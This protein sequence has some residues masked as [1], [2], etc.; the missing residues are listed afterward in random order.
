MTL[1]NFWSKHALMT[2]NPPLHLFV[3]GNS[4]GNCYES[5]YA[6]AIKEPLNQVCSVSFLMSRHTDPNPHL[7]LSTTHN[8]ILIICLCCDYLF[9]INQT[10]ISDGY[11]RYLKDV[12]NRSPGLPIDEHGRLVDKSGATSKLRSRL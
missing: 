6:A 2:L 10:T 8:L 12:L 7:S 9:L 3:T 1:S 5:L 11:Q 4:V